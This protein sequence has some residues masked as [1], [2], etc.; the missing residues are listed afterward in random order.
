MRLADKI[1]LVTGGGT[2]IG[3]AIA[4]VFSKEGARVA[5][6]GRRKGLLEETL[7]KLGQ[8]GKKAIS[9]QGDV[10]KAKDAKRMVAETVKAFGGLNILVNN[11]GVVYKDGGTTECQEEGWDVTLNINAK[12]IYLM[13]K[14]SVPELVKTRGNIVNIAST[15]GLVGSRWAIAY[16]ASKGAVVSLTRGMALDLAPKKVRVNCICPGAVDTPM[17]QSWIG[18][19]GNPREVEKKMLE[20]YPLTRVGRP[21]DVAYAVL[22]LAS[23][24]ASW[25]TGVAL[26]VDGGATAK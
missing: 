9:I 22:Y 18:K 1:A 16:G 12:G 23:D 8:K 11:A 10:S 20:D 5:I 15:L 4:T 7:S 21:E 17:Y 2:G 26:P 25:V 14:F 24:E 19:Y 13:S 3:R 6:T